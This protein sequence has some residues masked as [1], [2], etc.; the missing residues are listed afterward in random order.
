[1]RTSPSEVRAK[2]SFTSGR[3][4]SAH[5]HQFHPCARWRCCQAS[6]ERARE[7][8]IGIGACKWGVSQAASQARAAWPAACPGSRGASGVCRGAWP[9]R[10]TARPIRAPI[11]GGQLPGFA[12]GGG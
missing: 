6:L 2:S 1:V 8:S 5:A 4:S 12:C 9:A 10:R 7:Q 11:A 3:A